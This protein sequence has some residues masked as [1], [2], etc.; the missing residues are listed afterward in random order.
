MIDKE[1]ISNVKDIIRYL[2]AGEYDEL[3]RMKKI[4]SLRASD[5]KAAIDN[6]LINDEKL[7]MP[8]D[9]FFEN[10]MDIFE[11]ENAQNFKKEFTIYIDFWVNNEKSDLT[12]GCE[13]TVDN[14]EY[15]NVTLYEIRV[16]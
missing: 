15:T 10:N 13:A 9:D 5:L 14:D 16:L 8:P 12:L 1:I 3:E 6:Y 11:V 7:T 4:G 2:V